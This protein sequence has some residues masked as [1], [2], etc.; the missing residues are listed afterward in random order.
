MFYRNTSTLCLRTFPLLLNTF[1]SAV[2]DPVA[3]G[4]LSVKTLGAVNP[5][6]ITAQSHST[7]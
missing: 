5:D 7:A 2:K 4:S 3:E 1:H 6:D